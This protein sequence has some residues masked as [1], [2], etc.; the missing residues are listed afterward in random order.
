MSESHDPAAAL[1]DAGSSP[2]TPKSRPFRP[3]RGAER[4]ASL[5]EGYRVQSLLN[6]RY[7]QA[8][9]GRRGRLQDRP[10][11]RGHPHLV[12]RRPARSAA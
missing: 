4:P 8:G 11:L 3:I 9:R 12:Q 10:H 6:Q 1:A 7:A 2:R 5:D